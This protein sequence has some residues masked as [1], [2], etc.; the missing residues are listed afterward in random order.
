MAKAFSTSVTRIRLYSI[1]NFLLLS[2]Y[3]FADQGFLTFIAL[4]SFYSI[5]N[6]LVLNKT[7][8]SAKDFPTFCTLISHEYSLVMFQVY[9]EAGA[10]LQTFPTISAPINYVSVK[11]FVSHKVRVVAN[12]FA[13]FT[14]LI[15][16]FCHLASLASDHVSLWL[17]I[18]LP[19]LH[20]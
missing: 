3:I 14:T 20:L 7:V 9:F 12:G 13:T 4:I 8:I 10:I 11:V 19:S 5:V 6:F 15:R 16:L 2:K 17:K 18:C 1:V